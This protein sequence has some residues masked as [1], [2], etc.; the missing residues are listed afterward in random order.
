GGAIS[1]TTR[2]DNVS[3][4]I[5]NSTF[6]DNRAISPLDTDNTNGG[7]III[8]RVSPSGTIEIRDSVFAGNTA[9]RGAGIFMSHNRGENTPVV[10]LEELTFEDN[11][12]DEPGSL[13]RSQMVGEGNRLTIGSLTI[14]DGNS[15]PHCEYDNNTDLRRIPESKIT[16]GDG[17]C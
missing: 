5:E 1:I 8:Q 2:R 12:A 13:I 11:V 17:S 14:E 6:E 3:T 7:A 4:V 15:E 16:G 10:T 9:N